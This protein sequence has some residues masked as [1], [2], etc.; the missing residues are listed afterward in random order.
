MD[1]VIRSWDALSKTMPFG[2]AV[3]ACKVG[4]E[5]TAGLTAKLVRAT[6]VTDTGNLPPDPGAMRLVFLTKEQWWGWLRRRR[7]FEVGLG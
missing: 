3:E 5:G 4:G 6:Y 7:G 1:A 2:D